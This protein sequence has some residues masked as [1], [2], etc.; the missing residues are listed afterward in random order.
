MRPYLLALLAFTIGCSDDSKAPAD[1]ASK[2]RALA[3]APPVQK[4]GPGKPDATA[5]DAATVTLS[6]AV[7][8]IFTAKCASSTC[9]G[10]SAPQAGLHLAAGSA[11]ASLVGVAS[12]QCASLKRVEP[13]KPAQSYLMQKLEG[14]GS[15]FTQQKMPVGGSLGAAELDTVRTW[16]TAGAPNN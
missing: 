6:G 3:D 16:I 4:D 15:C 14:A 8:P 7:Q 12:A 1:A 11:H 2:D 9:H 10:G 5:A 13:G